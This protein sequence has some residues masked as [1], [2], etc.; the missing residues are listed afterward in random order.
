MKRQITLASTLL[1]GLLLAG[2]GNQQQAGRDFRAMLDAEWER[3]MRANPEWASHRGDY[4]YNREW[5][6]LSAEAIAAR[7]AEVRT[8]L[9]RA[10]AID[11]ASLPQ[12]ERLNHELFVRQYRVLVEGQRFPIELM[13]FSHRGGVQQEHEMVETLRFA[14][15]SDYEDW[16]ARLQAF[17]TYVDQH[18]ALAREGIR[19]G[20]KPPRFLMQRVRNQI[21][22][23]IKGG[24][25]EDSLFWQAFSGELAEGID[26]GAAERL[27]QSARTAISGTAVPAMQ[28]LAQFFDDEYLPALDDSIGY[29]NLPDGGEW[30]AYL[31]RYHT[32]T[33]LTPQQIHD[34][35]L[36]EIE[37]IRGEME[38]IIEQVGHS[39]SF[40]SFL[41]YLRTDPR[42]YYKDPDD[43]LRAYLATSKQL[44]GELPKLFGKLPRTPYG[45]RPI[46]AISAPDTTTAYYQPPAADGSRAGF[47]YV[48]LY[49]P[50]TR[51][52]YE[53]EA[54]SA[55]EAMP[56][57]HLQIA[58]AMELE[59]LPKFRTGLNSTA[60]VEGWG[61]YAEGLAAEMGMYTD[62]YSRF[63]QLTYEMWRAVRLVV[64]TGMHCMGWTRQRAIDLLVDNS[65]KTE[66]DATN[67][68]DRYIGW[69]GQALA[70]KIGEL[71]IKELRAD[72]TET[73][74]ENFDIRAF[75][76]TVLEQGALPLD[77][78]RRRIEAWVAEQQRSAGSPP[79]K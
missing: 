50:E 51:P 24:A 19:R 54:L 61:L 57:H 28:R 66:F 14:G 56:G 1:I 5:T 30:Y 31:A 35:G 6:D 29:C 44:D 72:A 3:L 11:P 41:R 20:L 48:N 39:G 43:L 55:H 13:P 75:H 78:L 49:R 58:L 53:I 62:P 2:C 77:V 17:G 73:L 38:K 32:T 70:Y 71:T 67:E 21:D 45:V 59:D 68:I 25:P 8:V 60:F 47:Y 40:A 63:G 42:F 27:R 9:E 37:R 33:D 10:E 52:I 36:G 76:D 18:I 34:I 74:G 16:I 4:R 22:A 69:P 46:P 7:Q 12:S 23:H 79:A 15:V 64:D 26:E 65:A